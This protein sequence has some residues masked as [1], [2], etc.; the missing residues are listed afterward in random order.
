[1]MNGTY[2]YI[3]QSLKRSDRR[4]VGMT[5]DI[6]TRLEEHNTGSVESTWRH[7]P[8]KLVATIW[9]ADRA[10]AEAFE[11]YLKHGSGH[12]FARRHF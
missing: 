9:L 5:R 3:L 11:R 6:A 7:R 10:K 8:W 12:A 2:I 1:M 4:Y